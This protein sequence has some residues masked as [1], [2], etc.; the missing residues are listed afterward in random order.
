MSTKSTVPPSDLANV[1]TRLGPDKYTD[2]DF[3][4]NHISLNSSFAENFEGSSQVMLRV[5]LKLIFPFGKPLVPL[6]LF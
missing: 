3:D 2:F 4:L 6:S 5:G 1:L